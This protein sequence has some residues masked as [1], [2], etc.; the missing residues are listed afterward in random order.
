[1][2]TRTPPSLAWLIDK[3]ARLDAEL[4]KARQAA[5]RAQRL[6]EDLQELER[7]LEAVDRTLG[8]HELQIDISLIPPKTSRR[9]WSKL[10]Y[11][12]LTGAIMRYLTASDGRAVS[13]GELAIYVATQ[14]P[15][16][17]ELYAGKTAFQRMIQRRLKDL[18]RTGKLL[19]V[20]PSVGGKEGQWRLASNT[21]SPTLF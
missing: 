4:L 14:C 7:N 8:L 1:M 6:F 19:R 3:R 10:P 20:H 5:D 17:V 16:L 9:V 11:G 13:T 15:E 12:A 21:G 2:T 18:A